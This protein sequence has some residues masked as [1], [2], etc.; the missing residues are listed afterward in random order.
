M[1]PGDAEDDVEDE[2][3]ECRH[4][5]SHEEVEHDLGDRHNYCY[6]NRVGLM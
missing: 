3:D 1:N 4:D 5:D 2:A 6:E